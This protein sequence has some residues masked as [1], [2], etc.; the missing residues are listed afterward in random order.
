MRE[1]EKRD[2][3][4][5]LGIN[6]VQRVMKVLGED[7][8]P[9]GACE[10]GG[11][12]TAWDRALRTSS[13]KGALLKEIEGEWLAWQETRRVVFVKPGCISALDCKEQKSVLD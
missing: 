9:Q 2:G 5:D 4:M 7:K 12:W 1:R 13:A 8:L 6:S 3:N 11:E 10:D